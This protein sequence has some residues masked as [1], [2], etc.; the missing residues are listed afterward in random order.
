[1]AVGDLIVMSMTMTITRLMTD[2][3]ATEAM[4]W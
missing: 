3:V 1:M 2:A 4:L